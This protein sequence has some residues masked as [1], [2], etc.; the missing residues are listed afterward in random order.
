M[1]EEWKDGTLGDFG[2]K[3]WNQARHGMRGGKKESD[4]EKWGGGG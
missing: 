2:K 1:A 3:G 4:L